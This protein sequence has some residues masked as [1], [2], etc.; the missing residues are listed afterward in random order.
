MAT[1]KKRFIS[2]LIILAIYVIAFV[3]AYLA[4]TLS[5]NMHLLLSTLIANACATITVWIFGI[6]F[7]NSSVY[8]P[9]WS[10]A[11]IAIIIFW[12]FKMDAAWSL[13]ETLFLSAIF[14]WG[15]RLTINWAI[16]FKG[17]D[18]QDWR[19]SMLRQKNVHMWFFTNLMGINMMPTLIVYIAL[20][21]AYYGIGLE[22]GTNILTFFGF[23]ICLSAALIQYFAD[24][25][26]G[27]FK[28]EKTA[29]MYIDSG[30]WRYSRHP[31]YF[32]EVI[33][34]WGIW[35]M[36]I[37]LNTSIWL[38]V[39]GPILMTLLFVSISIPMMEKHIMASKPSYIDYQKK[40]SMLIPWL[41][42]RA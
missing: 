33:F 39:F 29:G 13:N 8:D 36:Q 42:A 17:M 9:Y 41:R 12:I 1:I 11:P 19:Y 25:Q 28:K 7:K 3:I 31:N 4:F 32:G 38:T 26:M 16:R 10:V 21:P 40:V 27:L 22:K 30:L 34:W 24:K 14:I 37:S 2:F 5:R 20:I 35:V 23:T 18:H 6:I 15:T